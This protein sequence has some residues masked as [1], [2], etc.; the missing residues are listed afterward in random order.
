MFCCC[1]N[2]LQNVVAR[3]DNWTIQQ[4]ID[5]NKKELGAGWLFKRARTKPLW[6]KRFFVLT[7]T[8]LVYYTENLRETLKGE[9]VIAGSSAQISPTR[10]STAEKKFFIVS[11]P[12]CGMREFYA[13]TDNQR[14]QW[15]DQINL[16]SKKLIVTTTFGDL[17]KLGGLTKNLWM[18]R[19]GVCIGTTFE[20]FEKA[21][22]N[23]PKGTIGIKSLM[24]SFSIICIFY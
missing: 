8:K 18:P 13:T 22:D 3:P 5:R 9:I 23:V 12:H 4:D 16:L 24:F 11:H 20:Y 7:E 14:K 17:K 1:R 19:W 15:I 6:N 21:S 10:V 2:S